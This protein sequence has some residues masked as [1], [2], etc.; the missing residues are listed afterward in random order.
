MTMR[1][2]SQ[3][4]QLRLMYLQWPVTQQEALGTVD[5]DVEG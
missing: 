4:L 2:G 3:S 1:L 5:E